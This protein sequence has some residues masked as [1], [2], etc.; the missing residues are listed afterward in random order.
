MHR[1]LKPGGVLV[2]SSM[3]RNFDPSKL[4]AEGVEI[5]N[6]QAEEE[7]AQSERKL[8]ALRHFGNMLSR[9]IELE[10]DGRFRFFEG[11]HLRA[12][13]SEAG[14]ARTNVFEAFGSPATAVIVRAEK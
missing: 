13:V 3:R 6:R 5:L 4:Y 7:G 9:L 14:F 12:L 1:L 2:V 10:E 8:A 11:E